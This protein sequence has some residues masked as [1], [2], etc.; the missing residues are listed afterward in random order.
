MKKGFTLAGIG[1][2]A[3]ALLMMMPLNV[4]ANQMTVEK[5]KEI[6]LENS[7]AKEAEVSFVKAKT[8]YED[9]RLIYEV[10][11]L[12]ND[13]QEYEYEIHAADGKILKIDW[14]KKTAYVSNL[15]NNQT[16]IT[17]DQAKTAAITHVGQTTEN[18][19]FVKAEVDYE[20]GRLVYE[21]EFYTT[22]GKWYEYEIDGA[23]SVVKWEYDAEKYAA[24][25]AQATQLE[26]AKAAALK[27]AGLAAADVI[28]GKVK[29]DYEDGRLIYE[30][31]FYYNGLEYEFEIDAATGAVLDW[32]ID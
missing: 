25:Q 11:F 19:T 21:L 32:D 27:A 22:D 4:S 23:G 2:A 18:V 14:E 17:L 3:G 8:D 10:E 9:G 26:D 15:Q 13:Y 31:E 12:T 30:G 5:A 16:N 20:D 1:L 29:T 28:W 6:A 7:G 24:Y